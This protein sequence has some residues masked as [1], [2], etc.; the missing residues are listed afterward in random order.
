MRLTLFSMLLAAFAMIVVALGFFL[1][2]WVGIQVRLTFGQEWEMLGFVAVL[3]IVVAT[4]YAMFRWQ[5][6]LMNMLGI[7]GHARPDV[8]YC[9]TC[10]TAA[11]P[12]AMAC[13][14]CGGIRFALSMPGTAGKTRWHVQVGMDVYGSDER[15]VGVVKRR[16]INDF[17]VARALQRDVYVP[18]SAITGANARDVHLSVP[19]DAVGHSGWARSTFL[20]KPRAN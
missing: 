14:A 11:S 1:A 6:G 17:L 10:G 4:A 2:A 12:S 9:Q 15:P 8:L 18:F 20:S 13:A 19:A 7:A 16:R 5:D 3:V